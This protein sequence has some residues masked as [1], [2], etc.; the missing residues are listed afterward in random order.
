MHGV[1]VMDSQTKERLF[2]DF[3]TGSE[4]IVSSL[5]VIFDNTAHTKQSKFE[6]STNFIASLD[7]SLLD[8]FQHK[9]VVFC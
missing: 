5:I 9:L 2:I 3:S 4:G 1:F 7:E 6:T 8:C